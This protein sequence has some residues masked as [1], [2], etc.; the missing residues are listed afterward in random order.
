MWC[1]GRFKVVGEPFIDMYKRSLV[2]D[3]DFLAAQLEL[4]EAC[5][6]LLSQS[7]GKPT[8][9]KDMAYHASPFLTNDFIKSV[10]NTFLIRDPK[11]SI[12]SLYRMRKDF[13]E[14]ETGFKGQYELFMRIRDLTGTSFI[15][16][17]EQLK[18]RSEIIVPSYFR[19]IN[20]KMPVDIL[21]WSSG[22]RNDWIGRES[23]HLDAINSE[24]FQNTTPNADLDQL[25]Q[26]VLDSIDRNMFYYDEM[27][28]HLLIQNDDI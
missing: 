12:P 20:Q 21:N 7:L 13:A 10:N 15:I 5:A 19:Y 25:P 28:K 2:S 22:S 27:H 17:G 23:W 11:F 14:A 9:V 16:D 26:R 1:S 8:F 24:G 18:K 4:R 6:S 3:E